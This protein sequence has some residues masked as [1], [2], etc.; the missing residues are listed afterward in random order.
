MRCHCIAAPP[1]ATEPASETTQPMQAPTTV[2]AETTTAE[3]RCDI[4]MT[5]IE[6]TL[7]EDPNTPVN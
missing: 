7:V 2:A 5:D 1:A 6:V 4:E 3:K